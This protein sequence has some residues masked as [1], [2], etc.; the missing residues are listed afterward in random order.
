M[1]GQPI[2]HGQQALSTTVTANLVEDL[3]E[4]IDAG[5]LHFYCAGTDATVRIDLFVHGMQILRRQALAFTATAGALDTSAHLVA[6][7]PTLGGKV[8]LIGSATTGTPTMSFLLSYEGIM[9]G[10][11]LSRLFGRRR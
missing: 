5:T 7:V 3:Y 4:Y 2:A 9:G 8:E 6:S 10:R 11:I 1:Q